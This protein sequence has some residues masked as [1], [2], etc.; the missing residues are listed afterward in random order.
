MSTAAE[1]PEPFKCCPL[2]GHSWSERAQLL[3]DP[4][5]DLIGFQAFTE[6]PAQGMLLFNHLDCGTTMALG[7]DRFADLYRGPVYSQRL[8]GSD[9][10]PRHCFDEKDLRPCP[11]DCAGAWV[12]DVL[13][14]VREWPKGIPQDRSL[15]R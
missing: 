6:E 8:T 9:V 11:N 1:Q 15:T 4:R 3:A 7:V 14:I 10:C 2:C 12:R 13:Q 5:V